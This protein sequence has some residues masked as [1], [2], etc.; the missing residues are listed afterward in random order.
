MFKF[1]KQI[2]EI[3]ENK[4]KIVSEKE[5]ILNEKEIKIITLSK[6][7]KDIRNK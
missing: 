4:E 1:E 7:I 2:K 6:E 3:E 5:T